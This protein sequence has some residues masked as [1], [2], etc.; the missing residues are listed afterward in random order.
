MSHV[1]ERREIHT[2]FW[3]RNPEGKSL[4]VRPRQDGRIVLKQIIKKYDGMALSGLVWVGIST[5]DRLL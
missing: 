5:S 2:R 4:P 3:W 1:W